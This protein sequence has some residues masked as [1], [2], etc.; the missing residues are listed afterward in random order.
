MRPFTKGL[1]S[2]F[3]FALVLAAGCAATTWRYY[4]EQLPGRTIVQ[5]DVGEKLSDLCY[6][7]GRLLG[8]EGSDGWPDLPLTECKPDTALAGKCVVQMTETYRA[9]KKD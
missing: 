6:N 5:A 4:G 3:I 2:G 7:E 8:K 9:L 1:W